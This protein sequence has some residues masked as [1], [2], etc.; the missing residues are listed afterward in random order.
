MTVTGGFADPTYLCQ[1]MTI[2]DINSKL[3]STA[4]WMPTARS[5][6]R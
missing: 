6:K 2:G 4:V 5:A 3:P 1:P